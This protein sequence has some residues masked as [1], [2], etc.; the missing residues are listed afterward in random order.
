MRCGWR[1]ISSRKRFLVPSQL[2]MKTKYQVLNSFSMAF[3][4]C[5]QDFLKEEVI[6]FLKEFIKAEGL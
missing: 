1:S 4:C 3:W 6:G 2:S 5:S